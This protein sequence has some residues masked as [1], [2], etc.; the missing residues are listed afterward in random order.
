MDA[1]FLPQ[2]VHHFKQAVYMYPSAECITIEIGNTDYPFDEMK[3]SLEQPET[4]DLP[5]AEELFS[6]QEITIK[7]KKSLREALPL[8]SIIQT[9]IESRNTSI[10]SDT[11]TNSIAWADENLFSDALYLIR[12][13]Y[14]GPIV[15]VYHPNIEI[16]NDGTIR[17]VRSQTIDVFKE[18]CENTGIDLIDTGDA[19]LEH[20][21]KY[22]ELP[23][24]FANTTPGSGHLNEVGHQIMADVIIDYLEEVDCK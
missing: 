14:D 23:Y 7:L 8:L 21:N 10:E 20:Y 5:S 2:I 3:E 24:G 18:V 12:S 4:L 1:N 16:Q 9:N 15:F 13:Q 19:F 11:N 17:I 22:H 6:N